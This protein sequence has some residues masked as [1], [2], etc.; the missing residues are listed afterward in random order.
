M[1][2]RRM[3]TAL[4]GKTQLGEQE[5]RGAQRHHRPGGDL[6]PEKPPGPSRAPQGTAR[7]RGQYAPSVFIQGKGQGRK[8]SYWLLHLLSDVPRWNATASP[9]WE[10][11]SENTTERVVAGGQGNSSH[12]ITFPSG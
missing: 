3:E 10:G 4:A 9:D 12:S 11:C 5:Q 1:C 7:S 2:E 8:I 6:Q